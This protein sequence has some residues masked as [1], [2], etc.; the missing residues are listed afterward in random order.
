METSRESTIKKVDV[1]SPAQVKVEIPKRNDL[2]NKP[3]QIK[4]EAKEPLA[5]PRPGQPP[6][7]S[8][9]YF[10]GTHGHL[11][12]EANPFDFSFAGG[13]SNNSNCGAIQTPG[14]TRLPPVSNLTSPAGMLG[15][16][17][18]G[19]Y[20]GPNS[21]RSGPV[22][23]AMIG[24]PQ[25]SN[26]DYFAD[27]HHIRDLR[28]GFIT[29]NESALRSGFTPGAD[30]HVRA[31]LTPGGSGSMF[32]EPI[33]NSS[34]IFN[35]ITSGTATPSTLEFHRVAMNAQKRSQIQQQNDITPQSSEHLSSMEVKSVAPGQFDDAN[36]AASGLFLLAQSRDGQQLPG[37]Y[38]MAT[39][40]IPIHVQVPP[41]NKERADCSKPLDNTSNSQHQKRASISTA[42]RGDDSASEN[43]SNKMKARDKNKRNPL[44]TNGRRKASEPSTKSHPIK[45][46][47]G[48]NGNSHSV[49]EPM[50]EDE[51]GNHSELGADGK[52]M[53]DEEKRK[54]FLERNRI[55]ALKCRQRKKQWLNSLQAKVEVYASENEGLNAQ[56]QALRDEIV[57]IKTLLLAHKEC[58][59]SVA[60]GISGMNMHQLINEGGFT[61]PMNPYS[62]GAPLSHQQQQPSVI[63]GQSMPQRRYS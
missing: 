11:A 16:G 31:G 32:P 62:I 24:G 23:P 6:N 19:A 4:S 14:G 9:D 40:Q 22:S 52:K 61:A 41:I 51:T 1:A 13:S 26:E 5:P 29:A 55:A 33:P 28:G 46:S 44:T 37:Q 7:Q 39:S 49:E 43:E 60:Q 20:W 56:I 30:S 25:K 18:T 38:Q 36:A 35:P 15:P 3:E 17:I 21:L 58:P 47:K 8:S 54:N 10:S 53:T 27:G 2:A 59:V 42:S 12:S 50:S 57:H 63:N 48:N 34:S 45:K